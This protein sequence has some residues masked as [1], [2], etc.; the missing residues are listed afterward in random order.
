MTWRV[1]SGLVAIACLGGSPLQAQV[2]QPGVSLASGGSIQGIVTTVN[3]TVPLGGVLISLATDAA[4]EVVTVLSDGDGAF[5][6]EELA[7]GRY[8]VSAVIEGFERRSVAIDLDWNQT[9]RLPF[10]LRLAATERVEVTARSPGAVPE[11]GTLLP[12]E[13]LRGADIEEAPGGLEGAL[14]LFVGV[15]EV[16]GGLSIKGGLPNQ[17]TVQ[18]GSGAFVDPATGLSRARLPDDAIDSVRVLPN[19]YAVEF[20]RFSSGLV[21]IETRRAANTWKIRVNGLDP[22]F[23]TKRHEPL[24]IEGISALSPRAEIGGPL[25]KDT[26]FLQHST[27]YRYR[28]S[29]IPSRPQ[30]ELRTSHGLSS[31]SRVDANVSSTQTLVVA[32]GFFPSV[33]RHFTLG[34][35][36]PPNATIDLG[37]NVST[38]SVSQRSIWSDT[39]F[40]E[41]TVDMNRYFSHVRPQAMGPMELLPETTL[42]RF[43]NRHRRTTMTYQITETVSGS[44]ESR[45]GLHLY[46]FGADLLYSRYRSNSIS[47]PI[48][49]RRSDGTLSRRLD[50]G[51]RSWQ[52]LNS[53]DLAV[54]GQDRVQPSS[55]WYMEFGGRLDRD[56]VTRRWNLTPRLGAAFLVDETG[57]K[58]IRGGY[59]VFFERTASAAGVFDQY[60]R[61]IERRY[62]ADGVTLLAPPISFRSVK[63]GDLRTSRS[64]TW[65]VAYDH[66]FNPR[67]SLRVGVI[68]RRGSNELI[69][70][71]LVSGNVG[72][73][74]LHSHGRSVY[75]EAEV[76]VHFTEGALLDL[77]VS[78]VRSAA[79]A[80]LNAFSAF[81]DSVRH[82][83][84]GR[85]EYAPAMSDVP[86]RLVV[87]GR[88]MPTDRWLFI[89]AMD[90]R[91]G[92]PY[93]VVDGALDFVGARNSRRFPN[94]LR[95]E[96]G[97]ERRL[98]LFGYQPWIGIR[99]AN[100]LNAFLPVDVQANIDSPDFG[101]FYNSEYRQFRIQFRF[102]R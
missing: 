2:A 12:G 60:E 56:G 29:D 4:A 69:V 85:N 13:T 98:K 26:L 59:G 28:S 44:S 23:R 75:R 52:G 84:L 32:G 97:A 63:S 19:P 66:R 79:R 49:I 102:A 39:R 30:S 24:N 100:A 41:T 54:F 93:S 61:V 92:L 65:D 14:R 18:I 50:F 86:H 77:N 71:P 74:L 10:D 15:I 6:F 94:Y 3:G 81:Y 7:P 8:E 43:Y 40:S 46:K 42:G 1:L 64:L 55:R 9:V 89:G 48:L 87:R 58:V 17:S 80:D 78:Y 5:A 51:P 21:L 88:A 101:T 70:E 25:V 83:V 37:S 96:L 27:Q 20:G 16:P 67:W 34:T 33:S 90:W 22:S 31:F 62:A 82:P 38:L 11:T 73:L 57:S 47:Q 95:F 91:T 53:T 35:F 99:A 72:E 68:D 36:T 76:G 45:T